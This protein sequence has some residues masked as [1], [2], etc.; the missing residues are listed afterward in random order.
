[1]HCLWC[2]VRAPC[3]RLGRGVHDGPTPSPGPARHA[4]Y[5][6]PGS[7]IFITDGWSFSVM[8]HQR[9]IA[10][11]WLDV[12]QGAQGKLAV[13]QAIND[14][15]RPMVNALLRYNAHVEK[16]GMVFELQNEQ[17]ASPTNT[18]VRFWG[19]MTGLVA[20]PLCPGLSWWYLVPQIQLLICIAGLL[21]LHIAGI[22]S[23]LLWLA[24]YLVLLYSTISRAPC[25]LSCSERQQKTHG[26][27]ATSL[28]SFYKKWLSIKLA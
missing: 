12:L 2:W 21:V 9:L 28:Q 17:R 26:R 3:Y 18:E 25:H 8:A 1:M 23:L 27:E 20:A 22:V 10:A 6:L 11:S 19:L 5:V 14:S 4:S 24:I 16:W 15:V 13:Y 7:S